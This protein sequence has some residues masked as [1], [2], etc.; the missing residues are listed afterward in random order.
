[1]ENSIIALLR[2]HLAKADSK[3]LF[4]KY[5]NQ[6]KLSDLNMH[7]FFPSYKKGE[8]FHISFDPTKVQKAYEPFLEWI[9]VLYKKFYADKYSAAQFIDKC[10]V[11]FL[12]KEIFVSFLETGHY[13]RKEDM[14]LPERDYEEYCFI[15]DIV[16]IFAFISSK[17]RLFFSFHQMQFSSSSFLKTL[18][19]LI[20][21]PKLKNIAVVGSFDETQIQYE[22][23]QFHW[24]QLQQT[25]EEKKIIFN[26]DYSNT[27][28]DIP[29]A[30]PA[31]EFDSANISYYTSL[32]KDMLI[33]AAFKQAVFYST[34]IQDWITFG[35]IEIDYKDLLD[36][37]I[38]SAYVFLY[39]EN[40]EKAMLYTTNIEYNLNNEATDDVFRYE[41][42]YLS[43]LICIYRDE[44]FSETHD[45]INKCSELAAKI[46]DRQKIIKSKLLE[47]MHVRHGWLINKIFT[48]KTLQVD[49]DFLNE[50]EREGYID[51]L[52]YIYTL[53]L[54]NDMTFLQAVENGKNR[55]NYFYKGL[56]LGVK[57]KNKAFLEN[58]FFYKDLIVHYYNFG[59]IKQILNKCRDTFLLSDE[60]ERII[61]KAC[62]LME[63]EKAREAHQEFCRALSLCY[64]A[65]MQSRYRKSNLKH[66][67]LFSSENEVEHIA[68]TLYNMAFNAI[69]VRDYQNALNYLNPILKMLENSNRLG[70]TICNIAKLYGMAA[71]CC[72]C[73]NPLY[74]HTY[75]TKAELILSHLLTD[76]PD[77]D[78]ELWD[79]S[80]F[81]YFFVKG[82]LAEKDAD[83]VLENLKRAKK[84][85]E[86]IAGQHFILLPLFTEKA[87]PLL[88]KFSLH[89]EADELLDSCIKFCREEN[90]KK[91]LQE[92]L[93][94][95][96]DEN[97]EKE[98]IKLTLNNE[99]FSFSVD[100]ILNMFYSENIEVLLQEKTEDDYFLSSWQNSIKR[101]NRNLK[102]FYSKML[103]SMNSF[104]KFDCNIYI[105]LEDGNPVLEYAKNSENEAFDI[106]HE[107]LLFVADFFNKYRIP[108]ICHRTDLQFKNF[109]PILKFWKKR[110]VVTLVGNPFF[111]NDKLDSIFIAAIEMKNNFM[112]NSP[113]LNA[114]RLSTI[115]FSYNWLI[116]AIEDSKKTE[117]LEK[118]KK[119]TEELLLNILPSS[120]V[121]RMQKNGGIIADYFNE[122]SV[123]FA[124]IIGFTEISSAYPAD[125]LVCALND[126][127]SR[128]D[129]RATCYGVE[130]I[131]T[132]G[133]AYMAVCGLPQPDENHALKI[134]EFARGIFE[135]INE[136]NKTSEIQLKMRVGVNSGS[137]IAGVIGKTKT[138][139][140]VWGDTVNVASRLEKFGQSNTIT[141][142]EKTWLL[143]KQTIEFDEELTLQVKGKGKIKAYRINC[144]N[145]PF[146]F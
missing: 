91:T 62:T 52:C 130:K 82:L 137:V 60:W 76:S 143:T 10:E 109:A 120:I 61:N 55:F 42:H 84:H 124:D 134:M 72:V 79:D 141:F 133:D 50:L 39:S 135:D 66:Y 51:N 2:S 83:E 115:T 12:H 70:L 126:L 40:L 95:K 103:D 35:E 138:I 27:L 146:L 92:I 118:E 129:T 19:V 114:D 47:Y 38:T 8:F 69:F 125:K 93:A 90:R 25:I 56:S 48:D 33:T 18:N 128:F 99:I 71:L 9:C 46:N 77:V 14:L 110:N 80:L 5:Y 111:R 100:D 36:F 88:R 21:E 144:D 44:K 11:Y 119:R 24:Q 97:C 57:I 108:F 29:A 26:A 106:S 81:F 75:I 30:A 20:Q 94:L 49:F 63:Y 112:G 121:T 54:E 45:H 32:I 58:A 132:I 6:F 31:L 15:R 22:Y 78:F 122:V 105:K 89:N 41:Y 102:D 98:K 113:L 17:H 131:K 23:L 116:D 13:L 123:L 145:T 96:E 37:Y 142:S 68:E 43:A 85:L 53:N 1:M 74:A 28:N 101:K 67:F 87:V 65:Q 4:I 139:Y 34:M 73:V 3:F 127:F 64:N 104:F 86:S 107:D 59:R 7:N 136:F 16:K 140:D 117:A